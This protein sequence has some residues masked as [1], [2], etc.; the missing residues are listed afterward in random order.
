MFSQGCHFC[1]DHNVAFQGEALQDAS[2]KNAALRDT[3]AE[4]WLSTVKDAK[5]LGLPQLQLRAWLLLPGNELGQQRALRTIWGDANSKFSFI[6]CFPCEDSF[7]LLQWVLTWGFWAPFYQKVFCGLREVPLVPIRESQ[8]LL[9]TSRCRKA[10]SS[11]LGLL[12][13]GPKDLA[14]VNLG[15]PTEVPLAECFFFHFPITL[16]HLFF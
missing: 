5:H 14:S 16:K 15:I 3:L 11:L 8:E 2:P 4:L 10:E 13:L 7:Q 9:P 6:G 1:L 12:G